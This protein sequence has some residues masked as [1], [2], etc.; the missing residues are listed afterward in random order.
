MPITQNRVLG[1]GKLYFDQFASGTT[2]K[3][4]RRYLGNTPEFGISVESETL[5][6][7]DSDDGVRVKDDSVTLETN[8]SGSFNTDNINPENIAMFFLGTTGTFAQSNTPIV[9]EAINNVTEGLIYQLGASLGNGMGV[10]NVS[11]VTITDDV[12]NS[13]FVEGTDYILDAVMGTIE[14]VAGGAITTGTNLLCD[15]TP[16]TENR[17]EIVSSSDTIEGELF[18]EATNPKGDLVDYIFPKVQISPNGDFALKG[19]EWQQ[20][21]FTVEVL[22]LDDSTPAMYAQKRV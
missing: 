8:R 20:I 2:N 16:A 3:Q 4:G 10:R 11:A 9:D 6:H 1:K 13:P 12:P 14:I 22:K 5:D 17:T 18:F 7:F 19:D 21:G 15:Y